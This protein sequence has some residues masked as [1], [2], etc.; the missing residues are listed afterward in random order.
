MKLTGH[1]YN[2]DVFDSLLDGLNGDV[3]LKKQAKTT[4]S[5]ITGKDVFSST[6]QDSLNGIHEEELGT[7]AAELQFAADRARVV[8]NAEDLITFAKK[9]KSE[10]VIR[11]KALE[12]MA[13]K[14]CNNLDR[15][16]APPQGDGRNAGLLE[17]LA[18]H[19][20]IP[21]GYNPE[22]GQN[23]SKTGGYMGMS[24]NPNTIWDSDALTKL[25]SNEIDK[26]N[27]DER[28]KQAK[29]EKE[30]ADKA[31]KQQ[32]WQEHQDKLSDDQMLHNKILNAST[33]QEAGTNQALP[34]NALS[35]FS[36]DRDFSK[37]PEKTAGEMLK[38]DAAT[39]EQEKA[40]AKAQW[41]K[42]VPAKK[43]DNS[44]NS[45]FSSVERSTIDKMFDGLADVLNKGK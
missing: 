2:N 4:Q 34:K 44:A 8:V 26:L 15:E 17:Q 6:T 12:R 11:G 38:K 42:S 33:G 31:A 30:V 19:V 27:G 43:A 1:S 24:K 32:Y 22:Y 39:I 18:S 25:A 3:V 16:I 9:A 28:I 29:E 45:L 5:P 23:D 20:V 7:I 14:Y 35:M 37:I 41:N 13:Q 21:A 36:E 40:D 10:K